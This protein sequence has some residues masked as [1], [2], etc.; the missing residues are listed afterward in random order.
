VLAPLWMS[1]IAV[2]VVVIFIILCFYK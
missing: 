2:A 1:A